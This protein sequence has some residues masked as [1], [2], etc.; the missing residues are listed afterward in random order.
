MNSC[1]VKMVHVAWRSRKVFRKDSL[2]NLARNAVKADV[3]KKQQYTY[4]LDAIQHH[5]QDDVDCP[6]I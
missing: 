6:W 5:L 3:K 4:I 2:I 1:L